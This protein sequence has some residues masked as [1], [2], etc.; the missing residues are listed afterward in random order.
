MALFK[1]WFLLFLLNG[2]G[3]N[4]C[5]GPLSA[6]K[7]WAE[8]GC[9]GSHDARPLYCPGQWQSHSESGNGWSS[10]HQSVISEMFRWEKSRLL[11]CW[12]PTT[13]TSG[14]T[15]PL[16]SHPPP[17]M[18][19]WSP[20]HGQKQA[21]HLRSPRLQ[22]PLQRFPV[23]EAFWRGTFTTRR[24]WRAISRRFWHILRT[25]FSLSFH[26]NSIEEFWPETFG[27][28]WPF[29]KKFTSLTI[30]WSKKK[31]GGRKIFRNFFIT[32]VSAAASI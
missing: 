12:S 25:N 3:G 21:F 17:D 31:K 6:M 11:Q 4:S 8:S 15:S 5:Y 14:W 13:S 9:W 19:T 1:A 18:V 23:S 27:L 24:R 32:L 28:M 30:L 7:G 29:Q 16:S 10:L 26:L 20:G 2:G 22:Q